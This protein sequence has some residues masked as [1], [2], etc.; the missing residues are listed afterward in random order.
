MQDLSIIFFKPGGYVLTLDS[1]QS[2]YTDI[3]SLDKW[4]D[5]RN[6]LFL[7]PPFFQTS[8]LGLQVS[9]PLIGLRYNFN[10][11]FY[12]FHFIGHLLDRCENFH[13][14]IMDLLLL[15]KNDHFKKSHVTFH[16]PPLI[17]LFFR[18]NNLIFQLVVI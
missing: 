12:T 8:N 5:T 10:M 15:F 9:H 1:I 3:I 18:T 2:M 4:K 17:H 14:N 6:I 7:T 16:L 11:F 13:S